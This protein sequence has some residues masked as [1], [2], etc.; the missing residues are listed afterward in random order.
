MSEKKSSSC[1]PELQN[2]MENT[3]KIDRCLNQKSFKQ[4]GTRVEQ[5]DFDI[6]EQ[7]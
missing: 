2:Q 1:C 4:Y 3:L 7:D 5:L 6:V